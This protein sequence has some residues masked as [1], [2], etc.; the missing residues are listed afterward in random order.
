MSATNELLATLNEIV[1]TGVKRYILDKELGLSHGTVAQYLRHEKRPQEGT[2]IRLLQQIR[3]KYRVGE[4]T[5]NCD[6]KPF[7]GIRVQIKT[8]NTGEVLGA[9]TTYSL[10]Q[11]IV[12]DLANK[13]TELS[14][15]LDKKKEAYEK[16]GAEIKALEAK[17]ADIK[18]TIAN[19]RQ[20]Y[21]GDAVAS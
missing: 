21:G 8:D 2:A 5:V 12:F 9:K 1:E 16:I 17:A 10:D 7:G 18:K 11:K 6:H 20:I 13:A 3:E 15:L 14:T 4:K 19:L